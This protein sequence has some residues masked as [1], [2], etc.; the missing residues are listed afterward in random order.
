MGRYRMRIG[1]IGGG[2]AG[3]AAADELLR[4]GHEALLFEA[5]P[6]VAV[7]LRTVKVDGARLEQF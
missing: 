4:Q 2:V 6:Q 1:V 5:A 3:L 7:Q